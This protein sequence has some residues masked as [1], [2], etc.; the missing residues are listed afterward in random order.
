MTNQAIVVCTRDRPEDLRR[1]LASVLRSRLPGCPIV[2]VDQSRGNESESVV[3]AALESN[4]GIEYIR[5]TRTGAAAARNEGAERVEQDLM[6]FT[7]DDCEVDPD[8]AEAWSDVF[9]SNPKVGLAFGQVAAP[10]FDVA[11]GF[12]PTFDVGPTDRVFDS[13]ILHKGPIDLGM[14]ANMAVRR[15]VWQQAGGFDEYFGPGTNFPA[16]EET[17]LAVRVL[18][19]G[20][21]IAHAAGPRVLHHGF[22]PGKESPRLLCGYWLAGGAMYGKHIRSGDRRAIRWTVQDLSRLSLAFTR[23]TMTGVRPT[24]FNAAR[25]FVKG[26][27]LSSRQSVD[28]TMRLYTPRR[29]LTSARDRATR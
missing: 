8:W 2:I 6:L 7:D 15:D 18:D 21:D 25:Y 19:L 26:L 9:D 10:P 4:E 24:G 3:R 11:E 5:S 1:C 28:K 27:L 17:D 14:G 20:F 16:A 13:D 23:A 22:R 12:I 29:E